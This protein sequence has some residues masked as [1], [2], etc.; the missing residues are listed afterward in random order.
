MD[1]REKRSSPLCTAFRTGS[2]STERFPG[3]ERMDDS[4][5]VESLEK[6]TSNLD[7]KRTEWGTTVSRWAFAGRSSWFTWGQETITIFIWLKTKETNKSLSTTML[8]GP[9]QKDSIE[10][11]LGSLDVCFKT[12]SPTILIVHLPSNNFTIMWKFL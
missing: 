10:Q 2:K 1:V 12:M 7:L 11:V 9:I 4:L 3:N 5:E 8:N 6:W